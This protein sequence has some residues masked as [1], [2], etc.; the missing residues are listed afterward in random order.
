MSRHSLTAYHDRRRTEAEIELERLR[1]QRSISRPVYSAP[2]SSDCDR[3]HVGPGTVILAT[4]G[5][6]ALLGI[7]MGS[8]DR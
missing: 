5:A 7:I 1:Q 3:S 4:V 6:I 2:K 8:R